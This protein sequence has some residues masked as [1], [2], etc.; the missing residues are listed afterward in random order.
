MWT[1]IDY[2]TMSNEALAG[3]IQNQPPDANL[4]LDSWFELFGAVGNTKNIGTPGDI[5]GAFSMS[6]TDELHCFQ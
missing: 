3:V 5:V 1:L 6:E 4:W 2:S